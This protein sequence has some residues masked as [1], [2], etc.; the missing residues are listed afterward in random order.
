ML[1][2]CLGFDWAQPEHSRAS[3]SKASVD[4][5]QMLDGKTPLCA[6]DGD[7][8]G[9]AALESLTDQSVCAALV[10]SISRTRK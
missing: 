9:G 10:L 5:C 2:S 1:K 4:E 3:T 7:S 8:V 6:I